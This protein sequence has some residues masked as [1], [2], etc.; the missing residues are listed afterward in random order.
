MLGDMHANGR[1]IWG[2]DVQAYPWCSIAADTAAQGDKD[3][4]KTNQRIAESMTHRKLARAQN[5]ARQYWDTYVTPFR[6]RSAAR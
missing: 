6:H 1:G 5:R 2:D 4:E 3:A